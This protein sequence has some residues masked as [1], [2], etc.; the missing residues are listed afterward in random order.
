MASITKKL[1]QTISYVVLVQ[2][3][4]AREWRHF[5][6]RRPLGTVDTEQLR[7][8]LQPCTTGFDPTKLK[9]GAWARCGEAPAVKRTA[10]IPVEMPAVLGKKRLDA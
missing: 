7:S 1:T 9:T 3:G 6:H 10:G 5:L 8:G 4:A 2:S